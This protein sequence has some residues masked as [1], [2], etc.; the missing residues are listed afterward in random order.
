M[1]GEI[2]KSSKYSEFFVQF[3]CFI[4]YRNR[5]ELLLPYE[6]NCGYKGQLSKGRD[7]QRV[8]TEIGLLEIIVYL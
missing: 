3:P 5:F 6:E 8:S 1:T 7:F 2:F 4:A